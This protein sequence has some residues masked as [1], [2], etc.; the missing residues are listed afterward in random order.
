[1][2]KLKKTQVKHLICNTWKGNGYVKLKRYTGDTKV[3]QCWD[4]DSEGEFYETVEKNNTI[5]DN[6]TN[7]TTKLH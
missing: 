5:G 4:C 3:F 2:V 1:M 7:V 6:N